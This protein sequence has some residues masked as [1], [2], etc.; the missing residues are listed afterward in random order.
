MI[1]AIAIDDEPIAL[2]IVADHASKI[3]FLELSES[4]TN[5]FQALDHLKTNKVDLI[6]LDINM[7]DISG[8]DFLKALTNPPLVIFSTAYS[9]YALESYDLNAVD[10]LLKPFEFGRFLKAVNKARE[11]LG[12]KADEAIF[13]KSGY[14]YHRIQFN[15]LLYLKADGNYIQFVTKEKKLLSRMTMKEASELVEKSGFLKV[16][17]SY[18]INPHF[19]SK[20]EKHQVLI[21]DE[22]F[23]INSEGFEALQ[24][25]IKK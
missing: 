7:P 11:K 16:H 18:C 10:Y 1:K 8:I 9:E 3:P 20:I 14:E 22:P 24:E 21:N 19:I 5:A 15:E 25:T 12:E 17:R 13:I 4:F 2:K 6:F 23:P